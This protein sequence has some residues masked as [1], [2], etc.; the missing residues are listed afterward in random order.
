MIGRP[1]WKEVCIEEDSYGKMLWK[2]FNA[3]ITLIQQMR[4][5]DNLAFNTLLRRACTGSLTDADVTIL[6][7]KVAKE[8]PLR[9]LLKN[10]V[11]VQRK[12]SR[13]MIN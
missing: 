12:N 9:D 8:F 6:N 13:H 2:S 10:T 11:I 5:I 1:I 7:S 3:V 4:Q